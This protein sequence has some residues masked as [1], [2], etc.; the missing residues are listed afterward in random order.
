MKFRGGKICGKTKKRKSAKK[1]REC[2][3]VDCINKLLT[4][5]NFLDSTIDTC[6]SLCSLLFS[7]SFLPLSFL[8]R[9]LKTVSTTFKCPFKHF[10]YN[11]IYVKIVFQTISSSSKFHLPLS[12]VQQTSQDAHKVQSS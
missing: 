6:R 1:E 8:W 7:Y 3:R 5:T 2:R 4:I 9:V 10:P 11:I 12:R